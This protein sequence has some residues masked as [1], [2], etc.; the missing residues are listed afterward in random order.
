MKSQLSIHALFFFCHLAA[1]QETTPV[2]YKTMLAKN[3]DVEVYLSCRDTA[4]LDQSDWIQLIIKNKTDRSIFIT[5]AGYSIDEETVSAT[6]EQYRNIG[7]YG[8]ANKYDL[9]HY[10][11]DLTDPSGDALPKQQRHE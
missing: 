9:L 1:A 10:Y 5:D 4:G 2:F 7:K 6:G 11:H 3:E 8:Q